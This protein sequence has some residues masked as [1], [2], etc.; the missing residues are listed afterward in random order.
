MSKRDYYEVLGVSQSADKSQLKKAYRKLARQFHPDVNKEPDAADKFKEINEA[1]EILSDDQKKAAYDRYGHA[2]FENGGGAQ[3]FGQ[4]FGGFADIFEE[5]F[6]GFASAGMGGSR[7]R[8]NAPRRGGDL[9]YDLE[10]DFMDAVFGTEKVIEITRMENCHDCSGSGSAPGSQPATCPECNGAGELRQNRQTILGTMVNV[11]SCPRCSGNG[12]IVVN[13]C[14]NCSGRGQLQVTKPLS[15]KIPAGVDN[16]MQ[17]R[18]TGEGAPGVNGGPPGNLFI[19]MHVKPHEYFQRRG[20]DIY[21]S[22]DI[23]I[24]Q[25]A[26]GDEINVPTVDGSEDLVIPAGTQPGT[27]FT[28]RAR[29]VPRVKRSG[30][31]D[32]HILVQVSIPKKLTEHQHELFTALGETLGKEVIPQPERG[33]FST[34]KDSFGDWFS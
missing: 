22:L 33:F 34:L 9:R 15:V 8:R 23:N 19:V 28:L 1:Y 21:L 16:E 27:K 4:G 17:M 24:T 2:A 31:G 6:G 7:R 32:Q 14:N 10:I 26:L 13:P 18:L 5:V 20:D 29:G 12:R 30:R 3:D 11:V 25:A